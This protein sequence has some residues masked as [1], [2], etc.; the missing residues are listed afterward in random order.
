MENGIGSGNGIEH[1]YR[2]KI[3]TNFVLF[4]NKFFNCGY[5]FTWKLAI[6]DQSE[7]YTRWSWYH[8][9]YES[10]RIWKKFFQVVRISCNLFYVVDWFCALIFQFAKRT[11]CDKT[12]VGIALELTGARPCPLAHAQ[13]MSVCAM[14]ILAIVSFLTIFSIHAWYI[15]MEWIQLGWNGMRIKLIPFKT[16]IH[17]TTRTHTHSHTIDVR[18]EIDKFKWIFVRILIEMRALQFRQIPPTQGANH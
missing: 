5:E 11:A 6:A 15:Q 17:H 3:Q 4:L 10:N 9:R 18:L 13:M 1:E 8:P 7:V 14:Q 12:N 16:E 2:D